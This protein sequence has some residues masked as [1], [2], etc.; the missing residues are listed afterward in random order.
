MGADSGLT[1][2]ITLPE[3]TILPNPILISL[4]AIY[5]PPAY[6]IF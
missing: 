6:S 1:M 4:T 5:I 3:D 2:A